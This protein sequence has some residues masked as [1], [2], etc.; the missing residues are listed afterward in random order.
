MFRH[1]EAFNERHDANFSWTKMGYRFDLRK[2]RVEL[3]EKEIF[4]NYTEVFLKCIMN[5]HSKIDAKKPSKSAEYY[6]A[7]RYATVIAVDR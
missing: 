7:R 4:W 6:L 1:K 2:S 3:C 5:K